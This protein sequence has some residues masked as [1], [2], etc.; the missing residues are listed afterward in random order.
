M[1]RAVAATALGC[2]LGGAGAQKVCDDTSKVQCWPLKGGGLIPQVAMGTW[3]GSYGDCQ[4]NDWTCIQQHARFAV[5]TW[6]HIGGRHIDGAN[7]YRTQTSIAEALKGSGL[8][9]EEVFITTKCPG[10]M[11]YEA[12]IQCADDNL[13]MLGQFGANGVGYIDLLLVH[14]PGTVKPTCRFNRLLPECRPSM[15]IPATKEQLQDT[16]RGMEELKRIGVVRNIG[17]SDYNTA[18]L[19]STLEAATEPIALNQVEW[20]PQAHDDA[21]LEFC[22]QHGIQLQAWS[23][24]GGSGAG[25]SLL[26]NPVMKQVATSHGVSTAQVALRWSIQRGV[27]V[28]V[29][30][31]N[32]DH[33]AGDMDIYS[34]ALSA[35][36]MSA[37]SAIGEPEIVRGASGLLV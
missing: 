30:T 2:L 29:G 9:R 19:Q 36:E 31:A 34:F 37:I 16:W 20:N 14:F 24:L 21:H 28:V 17:V 7:D 8:R 23:P 12:I 13:Q 33:A 18:Q 10:T 35:D 15:L 26:S 1:N 5:E 27:A 22:Q 32:P 25:G 4:P 11:G 3:S 6:V